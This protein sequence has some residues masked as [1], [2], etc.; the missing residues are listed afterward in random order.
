[1]LIMYCNH[2]FENGTTV[3]KI[4]SFW[5]ASILPAIENLVQ[6]FPRNCEELVSKCLQ[7][8]RMITPAPFTY[9]LGR[10]EKIDDCVSYLDSKL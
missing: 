1:M 6:V 7:I 10:M 3:F 9:I 4:S 8:T 2:Y 5:D